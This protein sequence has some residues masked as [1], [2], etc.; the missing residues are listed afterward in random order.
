MMKLQTLTMNLKREFWENRRSLI[1][2]PLV[3]SALMLLA[4]IGTVVY[5]NV[6]ADLGHVRIDE[7][8]GDEKKD[9]AVTNQ[10][11]QEG[12]ELKLE[13]DN[14]S[15]DVNT[16]K[17][18]FWFMGLYFA[19]SWLAAIF[20]LLTSLYS[21]RRDKSVLYWKS[22]PVSDWEA[23][24]SKYIFA[25]TVFTVFAM[26]IAWTNSVLLF[27]LVSLGI[28]PEWLN[29]EKEM[30]F[31]FAHH[32]VWPFMVIAIS[33][34]WCAPWFTWALFS[35]AY[36][37]RSPFIIF[38]FAPLFLVIFEGLVGRTKHFRD[39]MDLHSPWNLLARISEEPS[40]GEFFQY[41]FV[42]NLGSW[43]FSLILSALLLYGA[44]WC[45][46]HRFEES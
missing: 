2:L 10:S 35:S 14:L 30:T 18:D 32:F 40:M 9:P 26:L 11:T 36:A 44:H 17:G 39:F 34:I 21:D 42:Q 37:K 15:L 19:F 20:Y 1:I 31:S 23:I 6:A 22:M 8:V 41:L 4:G 5:S 45:R 28:N 33:W 3:L 38:F 12:D 25:S 7:A 43:I 13:T 16:N 29:A 27:G 46:V 24:A